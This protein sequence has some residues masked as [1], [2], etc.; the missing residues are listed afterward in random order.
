MPKVK[1]IIL[2]DNKKIVSFLSPEE[3]FYLKRFIEFED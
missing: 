2:Y 1:I 3:I